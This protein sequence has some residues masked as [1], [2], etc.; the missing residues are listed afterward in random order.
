MS[1][2]SAPYSKGEINRAGDYLVWLWHNRKDPKFEY[3][4]EKAV[5]AVQ[6]LNSFRAA[7]AY[8][9]L[10]VRMGLRSFV[11]STSCHGSVTQRLKREPRIVRKLNRMKDSKLARLEDVGGCRVVVMNG[12]ELDAIRLWTEKK[13]KHQIVRTRDYIEEPKDLG[14][15]AVHLVVERDDHRIEVQLRTRGQ[16]QWADAIE[17]ADSRLRLTLKDGTGPQEMMD[18]FTLTAE[19]IYKREYGLTVEQQLLADFENA[20][21]AVVKS[22]YYKR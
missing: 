3:E 19:V 10:K 13:W 5:R 12:K 2:I 4:E 18:Y 21:N 17:A 7:H 16:Q 1:Q 14:Y 11:H 15:R 9:L 20:R 6:V 22:G 8:P